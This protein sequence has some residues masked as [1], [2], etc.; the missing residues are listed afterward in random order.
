MIDPF[1]QPA[2]WQPHSAVWSA[3]PSH[4]DLWLE[5][6]EPARAEIAALFAA[7]ADID[8]KTGKPRG[9]QLR[10]LACGDGA[11]ASAHSALD[12]LGAEIVPA[13]FGDIWLRDTAPI[14][15]ARASQLRA[16]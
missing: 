6:L 15:T 9:E 1:V 11:V 14:F 7:I 4:A 12:R 10:I 8:P 5:D 2:E 3:W 13:A 16:A